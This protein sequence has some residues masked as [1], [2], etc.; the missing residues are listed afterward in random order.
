[1]GT[2]VSLHAHPD[3]ESIATGGTLHRATAAGHRA[4]LVFGTRGELGEPVP[5][6]LGP[7]EQLTMRRTAEVYESARILGVERVE[8]LG[9]TDSGMMGEATNDAPWCFWQ[10][11]V[12]RAARRLAAILTEEQPDVLTIYDDNGGYGHPDHIQV[13]RV[14]KRAAELAGV[15]V[16]AQSSINRDVI[17]D[18]ISKAA[19]FG[20]EMPDMDG[21]EPDGVSMAA[22]VP[23]G[24]PNAT[25]GNGNEPPVL[26]AEQLA[27]AESRT[28]APDFGKPESDM[29]HRVDVSGHLEAKRASMLAHA[30]QIPPD[31]FL[32]SMPI[33]AFEYAFGGEW[34]IVDLASGAEPPA[35]FSEI[36]DIKPVREP[37]SAD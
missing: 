1:M 8:F 30:S 12:E 35:L 27:E 32:V 21:P 19:E 13:H 24:D 25:G 29:T 26:S 14:G 23:P 15:P 4:V 5:G 34:F 16:V 33:E 36:F 7:D 37:A 18:A 31:H 28:Q 22:G 9:Y 11:D 20:V 6:V 2:I 3:D 10:A 17:A